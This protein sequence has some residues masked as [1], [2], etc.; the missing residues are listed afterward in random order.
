MP[1]LAESAGRERPP[2][3]LKRVGRF[4]ALDLGEDRLDFGLDP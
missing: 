2:I 1:I 4:L 3:I